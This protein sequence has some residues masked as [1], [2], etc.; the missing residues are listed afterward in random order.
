MRCSSFFYDH[1][2]L[3]P[4]KWYWRVEP[5]ID[6]TCSITYDPFVEMTKHGKTYGYTIALWEK[7]RTAASLC[8][9][10]S[11]YKMRM[12]YSTTSLW[13]AMMAA[14]YMPWPF[15]Y[16]MAWLRNRDASG[17]YGSCAITGQTSRSQLWT[18]FP[19]HSIGICFAFW[20]RMADSTTRGEVMRRCTVWRLGCSSGRSRC[21]T[22]LTLG[23]G[24]RNFSTARLC[25]PKP[26]TAKGCWYREQVRSR[27]NCIPGKSLGTNVSAILGPSSLMRPVSTASRPQP[28]KLANNRPLARCRS[29][30]WHFG[31]KSLLWCLMM[32]LTI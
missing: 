15:R 5:G 2:A 4:Y 31:A 10:F 8:R 1:P 23:T 28:C 13:T 19:C 9:K 29:E 17:D 12:H 25:R 20:T 7:G 18:C 30:R 3:K 6:F 26:R 11:A 14:S 16:L 21:I 27:L 22:F 32:G 24:M